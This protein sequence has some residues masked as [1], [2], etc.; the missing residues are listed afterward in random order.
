MR[1]NVIRLLVPCSRR[2]PAGLGLPSICVSVWPAEIIFVF[3]ITGKLFMQSTWTDNP[4]MG[5]EYP[6]IILGKMASEGSEQP[7][8]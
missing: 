1:M 4:Q 8:I 6:G 2:E 7:Q 3:M 5:S